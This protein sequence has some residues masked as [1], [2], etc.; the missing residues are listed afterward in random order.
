[1]DAA[2]Q[3]KT[4]LCSGDAYTPRLEFVWKNHLKNIVIFFNICDF[5][6]HSQFCH[7]YKV[8]ASYNCQDFMLIGQLALL[9]HQIYV[10]VL[11]FTLFVH[12]ECNQIRNLITTDV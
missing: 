11:G 2:V 7:I 6:H 8:T 3:K 10:P 5:F 1:M 9:K 4:I 12:T